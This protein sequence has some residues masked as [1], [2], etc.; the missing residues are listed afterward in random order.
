[1]LLLMHTL[2]GLPVEL[3]TQLNP[4]YIW[5]VLEQPS[6]FIELPS[7]HWVSVDKIWPSPH[8]YI[9]YVTDEL[10]KPDLHTHCD[11]DNMSLFVRLHDVQLVYMTEQVT[12]GA[13]QAKGDGAQ[14]TFP[15]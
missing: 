11:D 1:M 13:V 10:T 6:P 2:V 8:I 7:S 12:Q 5:H 14:V 3:L 9:Q 4:D 15:S